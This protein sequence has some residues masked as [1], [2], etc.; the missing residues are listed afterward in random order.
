[1]EDLRAVISA[2]LHGSALRAVLKSIVT[3]CLLVCTPMLLRAQE[4]VP[5]APDA[6]PHSVTFVLDW[7]RFDRLAEVARE[8]APSEK[9]TDVARSLK[10]NVPGEAGRMSPLDWYSL[11][12]A[13]VACHYPAAK[14]KAIVRDTSA[15]EGEELYALLR[16]GYRLNALQSARIHARLLSLMGVPSELMTGLVRGTGIDT[17]SWV[18]SQVGQTWMRVDLANCLP[19]TAGEWHP[20][21]AFF[22]SSSDLDGVLAFLKV[23]LPDGEMTARQQ[24]LKQPL[25]LAEW[26]AWSKAESRIR[27]RA[28]TPGGDLL[29]ASKTGLFT[30][31]PVGDTDARDNIIAPPTPE[32]LSALEQLRRKPYR[33]TRG[34]YLAATARKYVGLPYVWG[35]ES[36]TN[37]FDCS[38]LVHYVCR[39][40]GISLP[41]T[42]ADQY[43]VG[44]PVSFMDLEPGDLVFLANTYKPG[45]SHVGMYIGDGQWVQAAGTGIGVVVGDVPYFDAGNGPGARRLNLAHL[46]T[47]AGEPAPDKTPKR[48]AIASRHAAQSRTAPTPTASGGIVTVKVCGDTGRIANSGCDTYKL[49]HMPKS[50]AKS[51]GRCYRH[52]PLPG[53]R[54]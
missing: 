42:A 24:G 36:P 33:P 31:N 20:S 14:G 8:T 13:W 9:L 32:A 23:H 54:W 46:P 11:G 30:P 39:T 53:E 29:Y 5:L 15:M 27:N 49:V 38:G 45:V 25:S 35:G 43:H 16:K 4:Q 18:L 51:L 52:K 41:R 28:L 12:S 2:R 50:R 21:T 19:A 10:A 44:R 22:Q 6:T 48:T 34:E 3:L 47:V 26:Q 37:G 40:W 7:A 17:G 1:L